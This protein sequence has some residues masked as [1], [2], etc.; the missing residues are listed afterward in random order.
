M[1]D[2]MRCAIY[3]RYSTDM[4]RDSSVEDQ[5]RRCREYATARGWIVLDDFVRCDQAV[6]AASLAGRNGLLSLAEEARRR[7]RPFDRLLVDDTSRFARNIVDGLKLIEVLRW[8]GV[9]VVAVSQGID[10]EQKTARQ[11][12]TL[13]GM[14]DEQYIAGVA[15]KVHRGQEGRMLKGLQPG[16]RCY[17]YRN[18]PIEDPTNLGKYGRPVV[19]GVRLEIDDE[20]AAVVRSIFEMHASG[21]GL[22]AIAKKLNAEGVQS[23]QLARGRQQRSWC[24]SSIHEMLR[25]ER[26]RGWHVW[27]RTKKER[28][29]ETG[30][31]VSRPRPQ[32]EWKRVEVPE[33][34]IV[35]EELWNEVHRR[36][37]FVRSRFGTSSATGVVSSAG[38]KYLFSGLLVCGECGARMT[39]MA[40]GKRNWQRYGCPNYTNRGTCGNRTRIRRDRLEEQLLAGLERRVLR[41]EVIEYAI[42]RFEKALQGRLRTLQEDDA[43]HRGKLSK[44]KAEK[45]NLRE[46]AD[47]LIA[48]IAA[49]GHSS[50]LLSRL[51]EVEA[52]IAK[53]ERRMEELQPPDVTVQVGQIREFVTARLLNLADLLRKDHARTRKMLME[54][55][56]QIV[57]TPVEQGR[58]KFF[59]VSGEWGLLPAGVAA[60]SNKGGEFRLVAREGIEPPTRGFSVRCST[61]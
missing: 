3:A 22:S 53:V 4:Q 49:A 12:L 56:Q 24:A 34:R 10:S 50:L 8:N 60:R 13:H 48:A 41:P 19:L 30:R 5:I 14:I 29:P 9:Y 20:Q 55:C 44:L 6:S 45:A 58:D 40:G 52:S 57:L 46:Q 26:Y 61:N 2:A 35:P 43:A 39:I 28:N 7:P 11:L 54:H 47:R 36:I 51:A 1:P 59:A 25:N 38:A 17:G 33:W 37:A 15:D 32:S 27:N 42:S 21:M 23:P 31:K 16:G 18:V